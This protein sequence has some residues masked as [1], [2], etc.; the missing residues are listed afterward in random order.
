VPWKASRAAKSD[1][2]LGI[3]LMAL[4]RTN[5]DDPSTTPAGLYKFCISTIIHGEKLKL[6]ADQ[7]W[8][9]ASEG[10]PWKTGKVLFQDACEIGARMPVILSDAAKNADE[11]L[12]W[13]ILPGIDVSDSET[14]FRFDNIK[15]IR[16]HRR[17]E[18]VLRSTNRKI[19]FPYIRPY[20]ICL[21][22]DFL[23]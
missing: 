20:A 11:L 6:F 14:R 10:N 19:K 8:G 9:E 23:D 22:P 2:V 17:Q 16:G 5:K 1:E 7:D 18:L 4:R 13:G 15:K 21:T 3:E 12:F